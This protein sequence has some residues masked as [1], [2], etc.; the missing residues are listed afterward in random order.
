MTAQ[1]IAIDGPSGAGK[2]TAARLVAQKLGYL[3]ID[4]G[5]MYRAV[6]LIAMREKID[7]ADEQALA[8]LTE[9]LD[10]RLE[11]GGG[12]AYRVSVDGSDV[13]AAIRHPEVGN[14]ASAVSTVGGVRQML[15]DKVNSVNRKLSMKMVLSPPFRS[16]PTKASVCV[17]AV[18]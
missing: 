8:A 13:S 14:A 6:G 18:V 5:A 2:S 17:P 11:S 15:A 9:R 10:I 3:Y 12:E 16:V 1:Q 4:T 7:F